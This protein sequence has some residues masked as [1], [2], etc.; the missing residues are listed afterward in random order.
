VTALAEEVYLRLVDVE[1]VQEWD[2]RGHFYAAA[3]AAE[4][5]R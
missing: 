5:M 1:K 4:A 2:S 3:A